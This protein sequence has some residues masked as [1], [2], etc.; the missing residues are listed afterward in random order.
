M[1]I[2]ELQLI[3]FGKFSNYNIEVD[4]GLNIIYG[5]NEAGKSTILLFIKAMLFGFSKKR[6]KTGELKDR[7]RVIP[8]NMSKA[9]GKMILSVNDRVIEIYREFGKTTRG[10]KIRVIDHNTGEDIF[11]DAISNDTLG[12]KLSGMS[13]NMFERTVWIAQNDTCI[14]G[15]DEDIAERLMNLLDSGTASDISVDNA[16]DS[17]DEKIKGLKAKTT[18]SK[19]GVI[20]ILTQKRDELNQKKNEVRKLEEERKFKKQQLT[21]LLNQQ[22]NIIQEIKKWKNAEKSLLIKNKVQRVKQLEKYKKD[23]KLLSNTPEYKL[24]SENYSDDKNNKINNSN[25]EVRNLKEKLYLESKTISDELNQNYSNQSA[26]QQKLLSLKQELK[27]LEIEE[28]RKKDIEKQNETNSDK[29]KAR[30]MFPIIGVIVI[31]LG[32]S[33][34]AANINNI[35]SCVISV[36]CFLFGSFL[37]SRYFIKKAKNAKIQDI[38]VSVQNIEIDNSIL[39]KIKKYENE[40]ELLGEEYNN[41]NKNQIQIEEINNKIIKLENNIIE[42]LLLLEC[43]NYQEYQDK[44]LIY[45]NVK[46]KINTYNDLYVNNLDDDNFTQLKEEADILEKQLG[47]LEFIEDT[48][49][50]IKLNQLESEN[51]E[52]TEK[53]ISIKNSLDGG[54]QIFESDILSEID[55]VNTKLIDAEDEYDAS[56]IA[57]ETLKQVYDRIKSDY[58]PYLNRETEKILK[59]L[60]N[61]NHENIKIADDFSLNLSQIGYVGDIKR[62]EFFSMGTYNQIYL[63]LRLAIAKLTLDPKN[64]ILYLDD[65]L[66]TYD[67]KRAKNAIEL[68]WELSSELGFQALMF[69]CH[70]RDIEF[71]EKY[72]N[73]KIIK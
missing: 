9:S 64:T 18:R 32:L 41:I 34:F 42:Q 48:E 62:A 23:I 45:T 43:K 68:V 25:I 14:S 7:E 55:G 33:G 1:R 54:E 71:A 10:D 38:D 67:D 44:L 6:G 56:M 63:S 30:L 35:V 36:I 2:K 26:V 28:Q 29:Q 22:N 49:P 8:W 21:S 66:M 13:V 46:N 51:I 15:K 20:D 37:I 72:G 60:T 16:L 31:I 3:N 57:R 17:L 50:E 12:E 39:Q 69:T 52:V 11:G 65:A 40:L 59:R 58:T 61:D 4:D 53:I 27:E 5:M 70:S 47:E 19:S 73:I 24:F